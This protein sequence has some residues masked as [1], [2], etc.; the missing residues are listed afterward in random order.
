[1]ANGAGV[2]GVMKLWKWRVV[3]AAQHCEGTSCH[4]VAHFKMVKSGK[5]CMTCTLVLLLSLRGPATHGVTAEAPHFV[6]HNSQV[7]TPGVSENRT[8]HQY[9]MQG[10]PLF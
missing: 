7:N 5:F 8:R 6:T 1:M 9:Q 10:A 3:T 4:W 2:F